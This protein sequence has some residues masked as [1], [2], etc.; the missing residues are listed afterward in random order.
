[1][2]KRRLKDAQQKAVMGCLKFEFEVHYLNPILSKIAEIAK[3]SQGKIKWRNGKK[4]SRFFGFQHVIPLKK[5]MELLSI[6]EKACK[7]HKRR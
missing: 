6:D 1:M 5:N 7:K 3:R 2:Q 4:K